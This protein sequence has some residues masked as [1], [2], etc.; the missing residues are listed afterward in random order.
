MLIIDV[1]VRSVFF[2]DGDVRHSEFPRSRAAFRSRVTRRKARE[3]ELCLERR[4]RAWRGEDSLNSVVK[5]KL[6]LCYGTPA[7]Q[8]LQYRRLAL[9]CAQLSA[10]VS[11]FAVICPPSSDLC[12]PLSTINSQLSTSL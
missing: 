3:V 9:L 6:R 10:S 1:D 12:L 2:S 5:V 4:L 8:R 11:A 7:A